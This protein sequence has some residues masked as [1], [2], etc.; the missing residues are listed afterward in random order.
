MSKIYNDQL[1]NSQ[2]ATTTPMGFQLTTGE[3]QKK[4]REL[5]QTAGDLEIFA[6]PRAV[7]TPSS[8]HIILLLHVI[9]PRPMTRFCVQVSPHPAKPIF[10]YIRGKHLP[11]VGKYQCVTTAEYLR[12]PGNT[13]ISN[14]LSIHHIIGTVREAKRYSYAVRV[15]QL[16]A[17]SDVGGNLTVVVV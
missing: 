17:V 11:V 4:E 15:N 12:I 14:H 16:A 1:R 6:F 5:L 7:P 9:V 3:R 13:L 2:L 8:L 10:Y